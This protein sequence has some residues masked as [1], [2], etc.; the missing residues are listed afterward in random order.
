MFRKNL[1]IL[2]LIPH[3]FTCLGQLEY[4]Q[5]I[6]ANYNFQS[7]LQEREGEMEE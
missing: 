5:K 2:R 3:L 6:K 1:I 4:V 7:V